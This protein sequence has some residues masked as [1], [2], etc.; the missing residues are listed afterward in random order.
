MPSDILSEDHHLLFDSDGNRYDP[1]G[2]LRR[3]RQTA[4]QY[5]QNLDDVETLSERNH[6][7]VSY[8]NELA[9]V[10]PAF[11]YGLSLLTDATHK[12]WSEKTMDRIVCRAMHLQVWRISYQGYCS[13]SLWTS[14]VTF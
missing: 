14:G 13:Q 10:D 5:Y 11:D 2:L 9:K 7:F 4:D 6:E 3:A 8:V 1:A 12:D